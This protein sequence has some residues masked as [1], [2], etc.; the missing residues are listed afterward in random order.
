MFP[1][2]YDLSFFGDSPDGVSQDSLIG[3]RQ[4]VRKIE[5]LIAPFS[6]D[7]SEK[8]LLRVIPQADGRLEMQLLFEYAP[9][10][11]PAYQKLLSRWRVFLPGIRRMDMRA[12]QIVPIDP[13][14]LNVKV[15]LV[16]ASAQ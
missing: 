8:R 3:S 10:K 11:I 6:V 12:G 15:V 16:T 7:R 9:R 2:S 14:L 13:L 1:I 5:H 4:I